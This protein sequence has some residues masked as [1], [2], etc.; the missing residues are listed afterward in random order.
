MADRRVDYWRAEWLATAGREGQRHL[1]DDRTD[2]WHPAMCDGYTNASTDTY[3]ARSTRVDRSDFD[4]SFVHQSH[5]R[6]SKQLPVK[7]LPLDT[8]YMKISGCHKPDPFHLQEEP[9][10]HT[11][12]DEISFTIG[13]RKAEKVNHKEESV[14]SNGT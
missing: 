5:I 3:L 12:H 9:V 14:S 10:N 13:E 7:F 6:E 1:Y 2:E 11:G 4:N 8:M